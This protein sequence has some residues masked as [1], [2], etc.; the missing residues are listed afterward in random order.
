MPLLM[1]AILAQ[2]AL[3]GEVDTLLAELSSEKIEIRSE[4]R[5]KLVERMKTAERPKA[6]ALLAERLK[7]AKDDEVRGALAEA[8]EPLATLDDLSLELVLPAAPVSLREART[9]FK[10][11]VR[12]RNVSPAR[13]VLSDYRAFAV[14]G[15]DGK[16]TSHSLAIGRWGTRP[17]GCFLEL[18]PFLA[19]APGE[20]R[21][22]EAGLKFYDQDP[23]MMLGWSLPAPGTYTLRVTYGF[24]RKEFRSHCRS[25]CAGHDDPGRPWAK[26][27]EGAK[28]V[29]AKLVVREE[30]EKERQ[31]SAEVRQRIE[32]AI[33]ELRRT[34]L[35]GTAVFDLLQDPVLTEEE[36]RELSRALTEA[37]QKK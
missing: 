21:D 11:K 7:A 17:N 10:F 33:A 28:A 14:F 12:M 29:E 9:S 26:A 16:E 6:R 36:R 34:G 23:E 13:I 35:G 24:D 2:D 25:G 27:L 22:A 19:L 3:A 1:L 32:A 37:L 31:A 4:A 18:Q 5:R 8:W 20:V 15:A 30:T